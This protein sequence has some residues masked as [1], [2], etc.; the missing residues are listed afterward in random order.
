M[1]VIA[2]VVTYN[3]CE[4][5]KQTLSGLESLDRPV[6]HI[7][8]IDNASTDDTQT[9]LAGR[10][11]GVPT[12]VKRLSENT[13]GAGGF[14]AGTKIA[15][16]QGADAIW[17]MDDDTVPQVESLGELVRGLEDADGRLGA[18]PSFACSLVL[19]KDGSLCEMNT[20]ETTWDWPRAMTLGADYMLCKS[21]SF[22]S[23]LIT[24]EAIHQ[25]GLPSPNFFIWYDDAEYTQRLSKFR[26]GIF[27]PSS[28]VNHLLP[29]NRG[30][31]FGDVNEGNLWKFEYGVRNQVGSA[32][33]MRSP[34]LLA[35]LA[36][37]LIKQ[38]HGSHVPW[39]LR[40]KLAQAALRGVT[41]RPEITFPRTVK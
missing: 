28:K 36:E 4:L 23:V 8:I 27:V 30:V 5:L 18:R 19:W 25:V 32:I 37:H 13:G 34:I 39:S 38:L 35:S 21:C 6:D 2:V 10:V 7:V 12:T 16:E 22:V 11:A 29:Q 17:L 40:L 14:A 26:P 3:R 9:M 31:N 1:N 41:F 20:P 33:A 15:Y 24:R